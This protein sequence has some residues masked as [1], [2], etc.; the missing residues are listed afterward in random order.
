VPTLGNVTVQDCAEGVPTGPIMPQLS[1]VL[2]EP[3]SLSTSG[4][5][6][7]GKKTAGFVTKTCFP[8]IT[9]GMSW[10]CGFSSRRSRE[11]GPKVIVCAWS[12]ALM[13]QVTESP[14]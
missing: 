3:A 13:V 1:T 2:A 11:S 12:T 4:P 9:F 10:F 8:L 5:R 6:D 7:E 14:W